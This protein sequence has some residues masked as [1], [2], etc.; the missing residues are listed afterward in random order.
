MTTSGTGAG[1][2]SPERRKL[3]ELMLK[4]KGLE[5]PDDHPVPLAPDEEKVLSF[6]QQRLWFLDAMQPHATV[7][8]VP[9]AIELAGPLDRAAFQRA[10]D[11]IAARQEALRTTFVSDGSEPRQHVAP[12]APVDVRHVDVSDL[13]AEERYGR[14]VEL[15]VETAGQP[16]DLAAGPL[17]R[18]TLVRLA[19]DHHVF[20]NCMHHIVSDGWSLGIFATELSE[21][22]SAYVEGR[23]PDLPELEVSYA[24]FAV[25]QRRWFTGDELERQLSYWKKQLSGA[26]AV[27][28]LPTD[29]P[30]PPIQSFDGAT[31][32][33]TLDQ[34]LSQRISRLARTHEVTTFMVTLAA[35]KTL[36]HRYTGATDV[37][38]GS[39]IAGRNRS[40]IE[41]LIGFFVNTLVLR[42]DLSGD[43]SFAEL[44]ERTREVALGAY[45][46]QDLPF[47]KLVE[48]LKPPRD[49]STSPV[50]QVSFSMQDEGVADFHLTGLDVRF[51]EM[52]DTSAKFDVSLYLTEGPGGIGGELNYAT[53][54]FD[55]PTIQTMIDRYL[56]LLRD[57]VAAP[58]A[59]IS[60]ARLIG[61]DE[62]RALIEKLNPPAP[63]RVEGLVHERIAAVAR[64]QPDAVALVAGDGEM[65]FAELDERAASVAAGLTAQGVGPGD[66]V[67]VVLP[68]SFDQVAAQLGAM[69]AGAAYLPLDPS[70][71]RPRIEFMLADAKPAA[72][73]RDALPAGRGGVPAPET[74]GE[75]LAYVV[76]TSGSTGQPKGVAVAH[77]NLCHLVDWHV[78][79]YGPAGPS[80]AVAPLSFDASVWELWPPLTA[81]AAVVLV[82]DEDARDPNALRA[83]LERHAVR[84]AFVPTAT[85]GSLVR[86]RPPAALRTLLTGGD[87]LTVTPAREFGARVVNHY[88]PT[89][90]TV[91]ATAGEVTG[92]GIPHIGTPIRGARVYVLDSDLEP[93]PPGLPGEIYIGGRG[94]ARGYLGRPALTTDRFL[95]DPFSP[96]PG[97]RMYRSGD[98]ARYRPDGAIDFLGRSDDQV[99]VRG[100]RVEPAE[101]EAALRSHPAIEA[102]AVTPALD[103]AGS[104]RLV[105]YVVGPDVPP[106]SDLRDFLGGVLP[107][108]MVP[109]LYVRLEALPLT[110]AGK[111]DRAALP[112]PGPD[113]P[114][115]GHGYAEPETETEKTLA[116][117]WSEV[118]GVERVGRDDNFFELGGHSLLG[119]QLM[120]RIRNLF[121]MEVPLRALF[122]R[123][124]VG[125]LAATIDATATQEML[126]LVPAPRDEAP[127]LSFAQQRMWF[128]DQIDPASATYNVPIAL[129]LTGAVDPARLEAALAAIVER[130]ETLRTTFTTVRGEPRQVV[131]PEGRVTLSRVDLSYLDEHEREDA[132]MKVV[133]EEAARPFDLASGPLWRTTLIGLGPD[134]HLFVVCMHHIVSD[135]W[136]L[137]IFASELSEIYTALVDEREPK[138]EPLPI[139]YADFAVWQRRWFEGAELERQ[140][141][142]WKNHLAGAPA[143]LE[144]PTDYPR[145]PIQSF[146]G[147]SVNFTMPRD[148]SEKVTELARSR[149]VTTFMF[150]MAAF[151]TLL[152]RYTGSTDIV[153]GTPIA[154]RNRSEI[155]GLIGFFVNTLVMRNDLSG[156]PRFTEL[157]ERARDVALGAYA[158]QDLP[159]EKLVEEL[160]PPR[161]LS[162]SPLFQVAF[163]FQ[164]TPPPEFE[165]TGLRIDLPDLED[166]S[167]KFDLSMDMV[168]TEDGLAGSLNYATA[169]FERTTIEEMLGHFETLLES[170]VARPEAR[171][172]E[173]PILTDEA[174]R[175]IVRD[176]NETAADYPAERLIHEHFEVLARETPDAV[177]LSFE[178]EEVTYAALNERANRLAHHLRTMGIGPEDLAGIVLERGVDLVVAVVGVLK[179][180]AAYVPV[181]PAYPRGRIEFTFRDARVA[182]VVTLS[183]LEDLVPE[184]VA[185]V[186]LDADA[187]TIS[188]QPSSDPERATGPDGAAYVIYTSGSTGTPK[189]VVVEHHGFANI[190]SVVGRDFEMAP[191]DRVLQFPS[192]GFDAS[193]FDVANALAGGATLCLG[194]RATLLPG[195]DLFGFLRDEKITV[196]TLQPSAL[197]ALPSNDLPDL[198]VLMIAGEACPGD[199]A[200][201]WA[202]QRRVFN[203]YGPTEATIGCTWFEI[204][205]QPASTLQSPP[206]GRPIANTEIYVLDRALEPVPVGVPGEIFIAGAGLARGYL[207]RPAVT[208]DRFLPNPFSE[209]RGAR[210]Y[211]T[212]DVGRF[213][214]DGNLEFLGRAD[215]Q[216]KVRGF[217]IELG[218]IETALAAHPSVRE[219]V[220][221]ARGETPSDKRLAAYYVPTDPPPSV[222][223]LRAHLG[224]TLPDYMIP[225]AFVALDALP[226]LPNGKVDRAALPSPE[227]ARPELGTKFEPPRTDTERK[228]VDIWKSVLRLDDV[229]I[230]DNF[231]ELGGDS[232]LIIQI[233]A[234]AAEEGIHLTAKQMFQ[235]Q[236]IYDLS[237]L[238]EG[239]SSFAPEQGI[240]TG[241]VPLTPIQR[242]FFEQ[243]PPEPHHFNQAMIVEVDPAIGPDVLAEAIGL[244]LEQHDALRSRFTQD[245]GTWRQY[246]PAPSDD[247]PFEVIDLG[248]VTGDEE[249]SAFEAE[250]VRL[251]KS[252]DLSRGPLLRAALF[253]RA[254]PHVPQLLLVAHHLVVDAVSWPILIEDLYDVCRRLQRTGTAKL[255]PKS[256]SFKWWA[257]K[258]EEYAGSPLL[259]REL[260]YWLN[261]VP[262]E[263]EPLPVARTDGPN[264][265]G[266]SVTINSRMSP[267]ATTALLRSVPAAF[268]TQIMD[269]LV[270]GLT[271]AVQ[272]W[273]GSQGLLV[274]LEGHGREEVFEGANLFA[275]VGWFTTL[276]PFYGAADPAGDVR[277]SLH[278]IRA[279]LA[280][281]PNKGFGYGP[282]RYM[283]GEGRRLGDLP[284]AEISFNYFGRMD[285]AYGSGD[286]FSPTYG[287]TGPTISPAMSRAHLIEVNASVVE[288]GL[289]MQWTYSA[290][291][292]D[293]ESIEELAVLFEQR[294]VEIGAAARAAL[295]EDG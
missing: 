27:L 149:G 145:P 245:G 132:A 95:P 238:G 73:I 179:S 168:E 66:L 87:R 186:R 180:G 189:G 77:S 205:Y 24:D 218:E 3:L 60:R 93:V 43:P 197:A 280:A 289:Q 135:G 194:T 134:D 125:G 193:L 49:L 204:P 111:V 221:D 119:T 50:F 47:E 270:A 232:I 191:S 160:K 210:M 82:D 294:I 254:A 75:D 223:Q 29:R 45:A 104:T 17:W 224:T 164:N 98:R 113:R 200:Q 233:V 76:Y 71:P 278:R 290:N 240:V 291:R 62:R 261:A 187:A 118:L 213:R 84:T 52:E 55:R 67:A 152:H 122:E 260:D 23:E 97:A 11:A 59:P 277:T 262:S 79:A 141:S 184:G 165:L 171:L 206:I 147:G 57:L 174:K 37:V 72:V 14:A 215:R 286:T 247:V 5:R 293:R 99:K 129:R 96:E 78:A 9:G 195:P 170:I 18:C 2:L 225:S 235:A 181:D 162:H 230:F 242:W 46:H 159:F 114:D 236:T 109:A 211:R 136:S 192:I 234:R 203:G 130:H 239:M 256:T 226:L 10:L 51:P 282:L 292:H 127:L 107:A 208:A 182:A 69:K 283:T 22:Y 166:T 133:N 251:Q 284:S 288:E 273:K 80:S 92:T 142:Y 153:L 56:T 257:Q 246:I 269:A 173:L 185:R 28:E 30:R 214:R 217:R 249:E 12:A 139:Q 276:Y 188:T 94:V 81:G 172:S 287:A 228:L 201:Q 15:A 148:L 26:P 33:F 1:A 6:G 115:L 7:Y 53:A 207:R 231:F 91:V 253:R 263:V 108:H 158:H 13:P 85:A 271:L 25:W 255:P 137:G 157:I 274:N 124:T 120:S 44:L 178:G 222:T 267:D 70:Y 101:V 89:E 212:G 183:G 167:A 21:L 54:L 63:Q 126:P 143:A 275:T 144:I 146:D 4:R 176:F 65:T 272:E 61:A 74:A 151:S 112:A 243:D 42:T 241:P 121:E 295:E 19:D 169:L 106:V 199:L 190:V 198:R 196:A 281:I 8:N 266:S 154:G 175:R 161:D 32:S 90:A 279:A 131:A 86:S 138:L 102:A 39:P 88:G 103:A 177:A 116:E 100:Y 237:L 265:V 156:D 264:D 128:I 219:A 64:A 58:D 216:V 20:A 259:A 209:A 117:V 40:E 229:G 68:R 83:A 36:L 34:D 41:G 123:P 16:F 140:L 202:R 244:V 105:A 38:V 110:P 163:G 252:F 150:A 35:F 48:E 258:M 268:G 220:V 155:E 31:V 227:A 285:S 248:G 250:A